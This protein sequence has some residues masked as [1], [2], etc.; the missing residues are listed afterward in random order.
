MFTLDPECIEIEIAR[1]REM[2]PIAA[3]H[4]Q[5]FEE[6]KPILVAKATEIAMRASHSYRGFTVG[7]A[8]LAWNPRAYDDKDIYK[9]FRGAN[10]KVSKEC[11]TVCAESIAI[12]AARAEGYPLVIGIV[13]VGRAQTDSASG[14]HPAT[15][16]PCGDCRTRMTKLPEVQM[17]TRIVTV[18][19]N[20]EFKR[21]EF[22]VKELLALHN[23]N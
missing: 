4:S 17:E 16:H 1:R 19:I 13:V 10:I 5:Y 3:E 2:K 12:G 9:I 18:D 15:L 7:C 20:D 8:L 22:T 11:S 21:E 14:L 6:Y 23:H